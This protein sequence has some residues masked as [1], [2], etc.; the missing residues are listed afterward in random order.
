MCILGALNMCVYIYF[1]AL[2][3]KINVYFILL[4]AFLLC[5]FMGFISINVFLG[6]FVLLILF[7]LHAKQC[8]LYSSHI[9]FLLSHVYPITWSVMLTRLSYHVGLS[10]GLLRHPYQ[11]FIL[12]P[13]P[14]FI[15]SPPTP[16]PPSTSHTNTSMIK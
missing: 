5:I 6:N 15:L 9:P 12:S 4:R 2:W 16:T 7:H 11:Y 3:V 13:T 10:C 8:N 1:G 14:Y